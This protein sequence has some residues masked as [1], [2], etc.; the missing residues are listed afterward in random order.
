MSSWAGGEGIEGTAAVV[1][2]RRQRGVYTRNRKQ[3]TCANAVGGEFFCSC[4]KVQVRLFGRHAVQLSF[5]SQ[6]GRRL[7]QWWAVVNYL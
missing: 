4:V 3:R 5:N 1:T 7:V 2:G 6:D